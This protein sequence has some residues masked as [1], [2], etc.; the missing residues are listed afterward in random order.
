[1]IVNF[2][3]PIVGVTMFQLSRITPVIRSGAISKKY[4]LIYMYVGYL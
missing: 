1:M 3:S 2:H 4:L